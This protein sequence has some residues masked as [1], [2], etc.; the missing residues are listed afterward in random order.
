ML[1][2]RLVRTI[3]IVIINFILLGSS[4]GADN[5][6]VL[7]VM[8]DMDYPPFEYLNEQGEA[9]GFNVDVFKAVA[10]VMGLEY[11]ITLGLWAQVR[12]E[13]EEAE[14]DVLLGMYRSKER[15]K[16]VDFSTPHFISTYAVFVR[17]RSDI[18][19]FEDVSGRHIGAQKDDIGYDYLVENGVSANIEAR[20]T[21]QEV[22]EDLSAGTTDCA[23]VS[24]L[25]GL[26]I[27]KNE[28]IRR[29]K[30]VGSPIIQRKYCFAVTEGNGSLLSTL[31]EGLTIIKT[32]GA[33][34]E[35]Y[36]K[37]FGVYE[38]PDFQKILKYIIF[39]V[40]PLLIIILIVVLWNWSLKKQ[41][42]VRTAELRKSREDYRTTLNSI[43]DA[44]I[45]TDTI[46]R[47]TGLNPAAEELTG[48]TLQEAD[49]RLLKEIFNIV[50]AK[51]REVLEN[52][53][54]KVLATGD[55]AGLNKNTLLINRSG[56]EYHISDSAAPIRDDD[57]NINGVVFVFRDNSE[58][59]RIQAALETRLIALTEP[60][61]NVENIDFNIMFDIKE[62][63]RLQEDISKATGLSSAILSPDGDFLTKPSN[64]ASVCFKH[65]RMTEKGYINCFRSEQ[66]IISGSSSGPYF[67][68][69]SGAGFWDAGVRI[70]VAGRHIATWLLGQ[71]RDPSQTEAD[72]RSYAN[73]I[74]CDEDALVEDFL[75]LP[76]M[77]SQQIENI[78]IAIDT[79]A[80]QL[81]D[82]AYQ[83]IQLAHFI[84]EKS[85][86]EEEMRNLQNYLSNIIDSMPSILIG[87]NSEYHITQWNHMAVKES[88]VSAPDARGRLLTEVLPWL[89]ED[90]GSIEESIR[91]SRIKRLPRK[92]RYENSKRIFENIIIFPVDKGDGDGAVILIEDISSSV[93]MEDVMIQSEKMLS[94]GG[95]AAGMAHEINNPLAGMIQTASVMTNRL[96][97]GDEIPAN[98]KAAEDAG[99]TTESVSRYM[100]LRGINRMLD[101]INEAGG[102]VSA[103]VENMLLFARKS[104]TSKSTNSITGIMD[105]SI[106]LARTD[107][108]LL[109]DF[110]FRKIKI[111]LYYADNLPEIICERGQIQQVILNILRN[112]AQAMHQQKMVEPE[113]NIKIEKRK[114]AQG[115]SIQIEDNG[116][117]MDEETRRRIFEPFFT[118][119]AVG[120]GTG[121]GLSVSYFIIADSHKGELTVESAPG[122]GARFIIKL[123]S[124]MSADG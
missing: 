65:I 112:G 64:L 92:M 55:A 37:W 56:R 40:L 74:G 105:K 29:I 96:L 75:K 70:T 102:R 91:T 119:K 122:A 82:K 123:P 1:Q 114:E 31:N 23:L 46:S 33:Y 84:R 53:V 81:S 63:Q 109:K 2:I 54:R 3:V 15:D 73:Q 48:W 67:K 41:V 25:Q 45:T 100:E 116:P 78:I 21:I 80:K 110:D 22:L 4:A 38:E 49:G 87:I 69:C 17:S 10:E 30:P 93:K 62:I 59:F 5:N 57:G 24:R 36:D 113:F 88:G 83:N 14:A 115:V 18:T 8:A 47:V 121:L 27:I 50:D 51:S 94:V 28:K 44:V 6:N 120:T 11:E 16:L 124:G 97:S 118:T 52:P 39:S 111:N 71:A 26:M 99:T 101:S 7:R 90:A 107:Y 9:E 103:I 117:G 72:I 20:M 76:V 98:R 32:S 58:K 104:E 86:S 108:N 43:G 35:I 19:S 79:V 85:A 66:D 95:L 13:L 60:L 106:E 12:R 34:D 77:T 61:N 42:S 89:K 68:R